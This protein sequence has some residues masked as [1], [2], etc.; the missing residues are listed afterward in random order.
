MKSRCHFPAALIAF[1]LTVLSAAAQEGRPPGP[2]PRPETPVHEGGPGTIRP[3]RIR[4]RIRDLHAAG[5]H[6]EANHLAE[7][8]RNAWMKHGGRPG[9]PGREAKPAPQPSSPHPVAPPPVMKIRN[10]K[11]AAGL[12]EAAGYRDQAEKARQEVGRIEAEMRHMEKMKRREAGQ[13]KVEETNH[14]A[15]EKKD[16]ESGRKRGAEGE[17]L[18]D[19]M[20]RMRDEMN[21]LSRQVEELRGQ[22]RKAREEDAKPERRDGD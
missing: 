9:M 7:R 3:E 14:T 17:S 12:L 20:R 21:K 22:L 6:E 13:R 1:S 15:M 8:A 16:S 19:D 5:K 10:L 4:E 11:Q 2:P 18:T